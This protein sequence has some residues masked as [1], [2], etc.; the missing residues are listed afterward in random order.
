MRRHKLEWKPGE[1]TMIVGMAAFVL[2]LCQGIILGRPGES[3][4]ISLEWGYP[5]AL[6]AC[7][8]M[9]ASGFLRQ[10]R[11]TDAKKPPGASYRL[12]A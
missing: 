7:L 9:A 8:G 4:E 5:I 6:L 11:H 3:V 1:I 10:A 12:L 2:V